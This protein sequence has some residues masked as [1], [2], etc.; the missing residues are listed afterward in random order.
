MSQI[1]TLLSVESQP[2]S[3]KKAKSL[4]ILLHGL[5][6]DADDL[7]GIIPE[8]DKH[9]PDTHFIS[10]NA[11]YPCD[12]MPFGR[13]WFS[14]TTWTESA[15]LEG[16]KTVEPIL[17]NYIEE[18]KSRFSIEDKDIALLGFSQ[19]SILSIH[20]ALRRKTTLAGVLAYSG[21]IIAPQTLKTELQSKTPICMV[22]GTF[23]FVVPFAQFNSS[24][25]ALETYHIPHE[26]HPINGLAHGID[27]QGINIGVNFLKKQLNY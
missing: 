8:F 23:D 4:V 5:G 17:N 1:T 12:M 6:A 18:Q 2:K 10:V 26:A 21:M 14:M 11:P 25:E 19:G 16:L 15:I 13:Q 24:V 7:Y 3:G 9:L 22:H 20:T 27:P